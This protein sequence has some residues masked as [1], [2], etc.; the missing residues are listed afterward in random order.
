MCVDHTSETAGTNGD[1][2]IPHLSV[3]VGQQ[4]AT[5]VTFV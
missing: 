1:G 3:V 4:V 2:A 5:G